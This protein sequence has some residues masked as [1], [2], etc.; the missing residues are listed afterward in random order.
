ML[1][2][3]DSSPVGVDWMTVLW[4]DSAH[5]GCDFLELTRLIEFVRFEPSQEIESSLLAS[6][7]KM[8]SAD[9]TLYRE[10]T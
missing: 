4:Q 7:G 5:L 6:L 1:L 8:D 3:Q 9:G 2:H 10:R